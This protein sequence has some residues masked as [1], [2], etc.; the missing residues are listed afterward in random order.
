MIN[1]QVSKNLIRNLQKLFALMIFSDRKYVDPSSVANCI[2]D[3]EGI[4]YFLS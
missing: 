2:A 4:L 3:D 1:F